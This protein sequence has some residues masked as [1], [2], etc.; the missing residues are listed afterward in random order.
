MRGFLSVLVIFHHLAQRTTEGLLFSQ[1]SHI[2]Y[3]LV[4]V[5]FF[6]SGYGLQKSYILSA[7]YQKQYLRRRILPILLTYTVVT[8][9][10]WGMY[11][12]GGQVYS[13]GEVISAII[14][15]SPIVD[16]SWYII[17][18]LVFYIVFWLLMIL[19]KD[20][21]VGMIIGAGVWYLLH[22]IFCIIMGYGTWWYN[23]SH[24]LIVGMIFATFEEKITDCFKKHYYVL[25][26]LFF[27]A[28]AFLFFA[29]NALISFTGVK[30][31]SLVLKM[32]CALLFVFVVLA[33]TMKFEIGNPILAFLG[34]TSLEVYLVQGLLMSGLRSGIVYIQNE[35]LWA[36][37]TVLGSV[38]LGA[39]IHFLLGIPLKKIKSA[40]K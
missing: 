13:F 9:L 37:A 5:F 40:K 14:H 2:G 21:Y 33:Y 38:A 3:L 23:T 12:I 24:I 29:G 17:I 28:F 36:L 27:G 25:A 7:T 10:F 6:F 34:K 35:T 18:I 26:S 32:V 22:V 4:A 39:L 19:C 15:G 31:L 20:N 30:D 11:A 1:L 8:A 16:F